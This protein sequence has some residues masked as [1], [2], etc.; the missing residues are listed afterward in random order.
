MAMSPKRSLLPAL[1]GVVAACAAA[2]PAGAVVGGSPVAPETVPWF[3]SLG[4][5]GGTLVAP[6]RVLTAAH[7]VAGR[8]PSRDLG[9][10]RVGGVTRMAVHIALHPNWRQRNGSANFLD[11]VAIVQLDAPVTGVPL[12][13]L[14]VADPAEASILG[15]GRP[16]A[17][18]TGHSEGEMLDGTLRTAV[19]RTLSDSAC[20]KAFRGYRGSTGEHFDPRMRCSIDADGR[21][22]LFSGCNGDSGGPLWVG[23]PAAP[24]QLGVVSWGGDR[25][26]A[27]HLPSVFADVARYSGFIADPSPTWAPA[28][29]GATVRIAGTPRLGRTLRCT[30][31]GYV[32]EA[33]AKVGYSWVIVGAG[34]GHFGA[35]KPVGRGATY[36]IAR[37]DRGHHVACIADASNRGGYVDV[38]T[39]STLVRR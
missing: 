7:C 12:V 38:G 25:C 4:G 19:L 13:A 16:F 14:G 2:A 15:R 5:C 23:T 28:K 30:T 36:T 33:G 39:G 8:S 18:G 31:R 22:P 27:D 29:T 21:P 20:A 32:P 37:A 17:P 34:R 1:L 35:P 3:A 24:V 9:G 11:D 6:A 10:V 26:G